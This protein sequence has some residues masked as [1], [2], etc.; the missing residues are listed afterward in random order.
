ML[1]VV[2]IEYVTKDS[3]GGGRNFSRVYLYIFQI[4]FLKTI[5]FR[6]VLET[7]ARKLSNV[8]P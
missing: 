3:G 8:S 5:S 4:L 2:D 6:S 7:K 1:N